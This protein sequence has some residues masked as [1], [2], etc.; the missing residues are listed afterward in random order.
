MGD[1]ADDRPVRGW[2]ELS[3]W[4][5]C[6]YIK[7]KPHIILI[8]MKKILLSLIAL[9]GLS[10]GASAMSLKEAF[11]ALSNLQNI[12][13]KT[14][15]YNLPVVADVVKDGQIAAGYNM[16]QQQVYETATAAYTVLNQVPL[17]YMI[18]GGNNNQVAAFV[19]ASPK[20]D[21]M[22]DVLIVVMSGYKGSVVSMFGTIDDAAK[23]AIQNAQFEMQGINLNM[24]ATM[25]DG[26]EFNITLSKAR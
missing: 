10:A 20:G 3:V 22:N 4:L 18:N 17:T 26:S 5:R 21:G 6:F 11:S 14:P 24:N 12:T 7:T 15:D 16:N 8:I 23:E 19:Y 25:A 13:V 2:V 1:G 9:I